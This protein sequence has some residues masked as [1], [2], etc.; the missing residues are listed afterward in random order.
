MEPSLSRAG[1]TG[2]SHGGSVNGFLASLQ[3]YPEPQASVIVLC[4]SREVAIQ[5]VADTL[6]D[7][8]LGHDR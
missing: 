3:Y 2:L 5:S 8:I 1:T 4:N 6:A 7:A